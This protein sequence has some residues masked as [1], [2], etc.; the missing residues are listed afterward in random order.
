MYNAYTYWCA[1]VGIRFPHKQAAF[2]Q[3]LEER[4]FVRKK[5]SSQNVWLGVR[6]KSF[7]PVAASSSAG[8]DLNFAV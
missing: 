5:T 7:A 2:N 6:L 1:S 3:Q 8:G 4:G